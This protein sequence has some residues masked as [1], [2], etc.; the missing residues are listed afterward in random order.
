MTFTSSHSDGNL[1]CLQ[2]LL[3]GTMTV[4]INTPTS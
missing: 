2:I 4:A 3:G 1:S